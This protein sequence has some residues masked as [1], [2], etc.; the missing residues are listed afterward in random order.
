[1]LTSSAMGFPERSFFF[2]FE[3]L[4]AFGLFLIFSRSLALFF[5]I[6]VTFFRAYVVAA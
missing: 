1:M 2:L 4:R 5:F 3:V 6:S